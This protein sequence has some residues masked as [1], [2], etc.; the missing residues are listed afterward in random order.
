MSFSVRSCIYNIPTKFGNRLNLANYN[1]GSPTVVAVKQ[2]IQTLTETYEL[3]ELKYQTPVPPATPLQLTAGQPLIPFS[4]LIATI[5]GN[6]LFPQFQTQNIKD[7]TDFYDSWIW[8]SGGV[9]QAGRTLDYRRITAV[10]QD[11]YGITSNTQGA[12]GTA[13]PT[14]FSQFGNMLQ[15]G[16]SPDNNYQYF[17]RVKLR[18]PFPINEPFMPAIL[19]PV[20]SGGGA[21]TGV[22]VSNGGTGYQP[23]LTNIP[24]NFNT[25]IGGVAATGTATSNSS[26]VIIS[27]AVATG[28]SGYIAS[29]ATANTGAIANQQVFAMESWQE[30]IEYY[31]CMVLASWE[32]AT[33]YI[34]MFDGILK[35]KG[36]DVQEA[37]NAK[38]QMKRVERHNTRQIS[39]RLGS[40]YTYARR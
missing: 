34:Q 27:V 21:V 38:S 20:V 4:T 15:V 19:A 17:I 25:P 24:V 18:H 1:D 39:L 40:P 22:T 36:F 10:D 5:P 37:R 16:P 6:T 23:S 13:P 26:G 31:A 9:N 2:A 11:S 7:F 14:Y 32:G 29:N 30:I 28:G 33:E 8:F 35:S 12:I 3:E